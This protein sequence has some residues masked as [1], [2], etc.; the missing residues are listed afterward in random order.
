ME[1]LNSTLETLKT[2]PSLFDYSA[3]TFSTHPMMKSKHPWGY[4]EISYSEFAKL[5]S[6][7]ASG[8]IERGLEKGTKVALISENSPEWV[9]V[10]CAVTACGGVIVPLDPLLNENE[11]RH[12]LLHS[13]AKMLI[14][15][16]RIFS[17]KI[18]AMNLS[19][20]EVFVTGEEKQAENCLCLGEIMGKGKEVVTSG[21]DRYFQMKQSVNEEDIAVIAY[22]SGTTGQSKGVMLTHRNLVSNTVS[23]LKVFEISTNDA[24]LCLLPLHHT[25]ATTCNMLVP[26]AGGASIVFAR[27][28]KSKDIFEDIKREKVSVLVGVPLIYDNLAKAMK[29]KIEKT[30]AKKRLFMKFA[31]GISSLLNKL[32][33]KNISRSIFSKKLNAMGLGSLR[34]CVSGAAPLREDTEKELFSTGF[35]I[36]QGY[37]LTEASPVVSVNPLEKP[38]FQ[39][40]GPP[41][42]GVDIMIENPDDEGVGEILVKGPNVMKG[43]YRYEEQ[44]ASVIRNGWLYTGDLG[45]LDREGYLKVVGRKKSLI[46]TA[47]GKNIYP[48][49]IESCI[50][51]SPYILESAVVAIRDKKGNE[52]IAA[53][54]VPDYDEI[55][56]SE[57]LKGSLDEERVHKLISKELKRLCS[58]L[59]HYKRTTSFQVR[60][61]ELPKTTT[62]K[63]KRHLIKW[64]EE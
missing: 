39:T 37:G 18:E 49:E 52:T 53:I 62:K 60:N 54:V 63:L 13:E 22:T 46:V 16:P 34:L 26:L 9:I 11:I 36:L 15:S 47:G 51:Q 44:T 23:C 45:V 58:H 17:E 61:E 1:T 29:K 7:L 33:R 42:P 30:P 2:L 6:Y 32:F 28:M 41:L 38:R 19:N 14:S 24:F 10:Y 31:L 48:E 57:E 59:P 21:N 43:Y 5:I 3:A 50:N 12:L 25:F 40:V 4:R 35:Q 27:S 55:S 64:V 8:L 56:S 20:I